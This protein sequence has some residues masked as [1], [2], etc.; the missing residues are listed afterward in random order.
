MHALSSLEAYGASFQLKVISSLLTHKKFLTNVHDIIEVNSFENPSV[1]WIIKNILQYYEKFHTTPT[2]DI[3]KIEL[4]KID[5]EVLQIAIKEKLKESYVASDEDL[6]YVQEEFTTFCKNQQLRKA[7]MVSA[8]LLKIGDFDGIRSL[9]D[10]ALKSGIDK[11]IGHEY[12]LD[13]ESRYRED[14]R[15]SVVPTPWTVFNELL[16]GGLGAGDFGLFFG[17]PGGGKSW[18][19]VA[20]GGFAVKLG[21]NVLQYT[22]ELGEDYVG[23]RYDAYFTNIEAK[24]ISE[25]KDEVSDIIPQLPGKLVI[26]SFP[27]KRATINTLEAHLQKCR[28]SGFD[29]DLIIIDYA[30]LLKSSRK[31]TYD[32]KADIDD[33][34]MDIKGWAKELN[35]PIW[36][37]SQVNR[38]GAKEDVIEGIHAASS[39]NKIMITDFCASLSR[40]KEDKVAGIGRFHIMKNR[41]GD[42]GMT[43]QAKVNTGTGHFEI[44]GIIEDDNDEKLLPANKTQSSSQQP[45]LSKSSRDKLRDKFFELDD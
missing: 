4:K 14:A 42:D 35:K 15:G 19:L 3:L 6:Q 9:V 26:K 40:K 16:Q 22:L 38:E 43:F 36:S 17:N 41:Y 1:Q 30:D 25:H 20:L 12:A 37:V 10:N 34:Y 11:N 28:D 33:V 18:T 23:R 44:D 39:Y 24:E 8:D 27:P 13:I 31:G 5:N 32:D 21:Y 7:L 2:L 29:P 45:P